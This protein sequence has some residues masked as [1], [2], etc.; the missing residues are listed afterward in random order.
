MQPIN[1]QICHF[2]VAGNIMSRANGSILKLPIL[3]VDPN[4]NNI[5]DKI[6]L[7]CKGETA[8]LLKSL[9]FKKG[10]YGYC[11]GNV[12]F[13][14]DRPSDIDP[15]I[16][17]KLTPDTVKFSNLHYD[18][19]N[20]VLFTFIQNKRV[21]YDDKGNKVSWVKDLSKNELKDLNYTND[22]LSWTKKSVE[23]N[24]VQTKK[25]KNYQER[26]QLIKLFN[27]DDDQETM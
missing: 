19:T 17:Q 8:L 12:T 1:R 13:S 7:F 6:E 16:L 5:L 22:K 18:E 25:E 10:D 26:K 14:K 3:T 20:K 21:D 23:Q 11:E 2:C 27:F 4:T 15:V 9:N 24:T